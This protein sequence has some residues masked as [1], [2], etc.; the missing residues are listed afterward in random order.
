MT[1]KTNPQEKFGLLS[2]TIAKQPFAAIACDFVGPFALTKTRFQ[3]VCVKVDY[4]TKY[5]WTRP[6]KTADSETAVNCLSAFSKLSKQF[7]FCRTYT[8]LHSVKDWLRIKLT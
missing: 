4:Y 7:V 8:K 1:S 3:H 2:P 5:L 6:V